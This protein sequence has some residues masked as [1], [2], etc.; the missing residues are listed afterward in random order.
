MLDR[1]EEHLAT[2]NRPSAAARIK[3]GVVGRRHDH[4]VRRRVVGHRRR[5]RGRGLPAAVHLS[6]RQPPPHAQ[7][8]LHQHRPA[9]ADA[10]AGPPAGLVHHRN[11]DGRARRQGEDGSGRV[12]DQE[13]AAGSAERDVAQRTC[14]KGADGVRLGQ[15][16]SDR[17]PDARPDQDRH[18]RGDQH[19]GRRRPRSGAGALRDRL[20]RQRRSCASARRTSAPARARSSRWSPP[21]RSAFSRRRSRR[22]SATRM[23]GVSG[24]VGR[25]HDGGEHQSRRSASRRSTRSTR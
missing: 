2:G 9:A 23:Y 18:G 22:R 20:R 6:D 1:K 13:P 25:Q 21:T 15:A 7:G 19:V 5:R 17:R 12:P 11:H 4:G 24:G 10:R 3:A 16:A 14:A 8:R